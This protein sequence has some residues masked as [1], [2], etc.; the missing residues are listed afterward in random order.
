MIMS[1]IF[2]TS[3]FFLSFLP[4]WIS[5]SFIEI[6]NLLDE[7]E[8]V[9]TEKIVLLVLLVSF[10]IS[11]IVLMATLKNKNSDTNEEYTLVS[12]KR[13]K[14]ISVEFL[15]SY[16]LPLFAFD[17]TQW[18]EVVLFMIFFFILGW[19]TIKYNRFNVNIIL[20][21]LQYHVFE[22]VIKNADLK[23]IDI[24]VI[25]KNSLVAQTGG[26]ICLDAINNE[27]RIERIIKNI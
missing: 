15:L 6:I 26:E 1:L 10:V 27:F 18:K 3:M 23:E 21:F 14:T 4:L 9:W 16:I 5:I 8:N 22:C 11:L 13:D 17:F 20:E 19:L 24:K 25:S 12:A 7:T 2:S